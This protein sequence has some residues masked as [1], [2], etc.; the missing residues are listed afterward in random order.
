M[1]KIAVCDDEKQQIENILEYIDAFSKTYKITLE[2][3]VFNS[4]EVLLEE[5][6]LKYAIII[7]DIC[8][9]GKNGLEVAKKIRITNKKSK[10]VFLTAFENY[11]KDGYE[12]DASRYILKPVEMEEFHRVI[13]QLIKDINL[14]FAYL[15]LEEKDTI[16]TIKI[17]DILYVEID[18]R[19][20]SIHTVRGVYKSKMKIDELKMRLSHHG[21]AKT[22]KS[23]L[24]NMNNISLISKDKVIFIN[25]EYV[26]ISRRKYKEFI[27]EFSRFIG[28]II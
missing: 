18:N 27:E 4:G 13:N 5:E 28:G 19:R 2:P 3:E 15:A 20:T 23:F 24:V 16:T 6:H 11:L 25:D 21:F 1:Y 17:K 8:M 14:N 7:L 10:I 26:T 12:V 9:K 22:H